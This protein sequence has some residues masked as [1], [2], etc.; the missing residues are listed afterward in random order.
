MVEV[1]IILYLSL[2]IYF[3]VVAGGIFWYNKYGLKKISSGI[4]I[5]IILH[6]IVG[7]WSIPLAIYWFVAVLAW[8]K[9]NLFI[10]L[11][12]IFLV[13]SSFYI[14]YR[15]HNRNLYQYNNLFSVNIIVCPILFWFLIDIFP[16]IS[17]GE[18]IDVIFLSLIFAF[19]PLAPNAFS[20]WYTRKPEVKS[21]KQT[22]V[23]DYA[24]S[25]VV[26][27]HI[28]ALFFLLFFYKS[29]YFM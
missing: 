12:Y 1:E 9:D 11:I 16:D 18:V 23:F 21:F 19:V 4:G 20:V 24:K 15:L 6:G 29:G 28:I 5:L 17:T 7:V 26:T 3:V 2:A 14:V 8:E 13:F 25:I 27:S 10:A 22:V